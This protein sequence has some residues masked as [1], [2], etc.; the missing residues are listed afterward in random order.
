MFR[1]MLLAKLHRGA[2]TDCH[3]DYAGSLTV[4]PDLLD[5][6]GMLVH[7]KIQVVNINN[8]ARFET[9]LI[10]GRRGSR[11]IV[12]N[13]AAARLCQTG[14]R[15]IV[16]TYASIDERELDSYKPRILVLDADN[17]VIDQHDGEYP[18]DPA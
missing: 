9:Y 17:R 3:L 18:P 16:L 10:P 11:D 2:V 7:E 13:G 8:G 4:D 12:V 6:A 15:V 5:Q 14:D 1:H